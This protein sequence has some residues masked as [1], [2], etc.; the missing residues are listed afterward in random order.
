MHSLKIFLADPIFMRF[1]RRWA[2]MALCIHLATCFFSVGF[3]QH[4]EHF[5]IVEFIN[6][7]LGGT[8]EA[9]LP[10]EFQTRM[11]PW[12]QPFSLYVVAW[13][14]KQLGISNTYVL[15][16]LFRM[17]SAVLGWTSLLATIFMG[18]VLIQKNK[19]LQ[20]EYLLRAQWLVRILTLCWFLPYLHARASADNWGAAFLI[21]GIATLSLYGPLVKA[22]PGVMVGWLFGLAIECRFQAVVSAGA[23]VLWMIFSLWKEKK[24]M[25]EIA[26]AVSFVLIG[27]ILAKILG[28]ALDTW[29]YGNFT[30]SQW[31]YLVED[32]KAHIQDTILPSPWWDYFRLTLTRGIPP[33]SIF[34]ILGVVAFWWKNPKNILTWAT[35]S[36][37]LVHT[38]IAHKE[39]RYLYPILC[40]APLMAYI[41]W[42]DF[43]QTRNWTRRA[44]W[45]P[46]TS[47]LWGLNLVLLV[48]SSVKPSNF[49]VTFYHY[50]ENRMSQPDAPKILYH[51]GENPY[52]M[53]GH[54]LRFYWPQELETRELV[55]FRAFEAMPASESFYLFTRTGADFWAVKNS[56]RQCQLQFLSYPEFVLQFNY[57]QWVERSRVWSLFHCV[58]NK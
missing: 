2:G 38:A 47:A 8:S 43:V 6:L 16:T 24:Q 33:L 7:K 48:I 56:K 10:W 25:V 49:A 15:T 14:L 1:L 57:T 45:R 46:V 39:L 53:V 29:G 31:N 36:F 22:V 51:L 54:P 42:C 26:K 11:R 12:F 5:Q 23:V 44:W 3:H 21:L 32:F 58:S 17:F 4:D 41:A 19:Q 34:F 20:S 50:M 40:L 35:L 30:I 18:L 9:N 27:L 55:D 37:F 13:P 28:I 52:I